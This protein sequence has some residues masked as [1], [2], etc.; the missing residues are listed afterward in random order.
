MSASA[1]EIVDLTKDYAV[2]FWRRSPRRVLHGLTLRVLPGEVFGLLGPNGAGKSTTLKI[3]MRLIFPTAGS[4]RIL[5]RPLHDVGMHAR[6]GFLPEN[7][8]YYDHLTAFELLNFAGGLF[9]LGET[10]RHHR[11]DTLLRRV[12]LTE[13]RNVPLRKFSKGM[14]QRIGIAQALM[15]D[16]ELVILDEPMS[17]L[18]PLGRREVRDLILGLREEGKTVLFSTHI[19]P[20]AESLCDHVAILDRGHLQGCGELR[21]ILRMQT[22]STEIV[23]DHPPAGILEVVN[24]HSRSQIRTG[25]RVR[26]EI[27]EEASVPEVLGL[28]LQGNTKI[29][30]VNPV[31][32]S[33]E[34]YFLS[35]VSDAEAKVIPHEHFHTTLGGKK[36]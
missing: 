27:S 1:I 21:E 19:L 10:E 23:V 30:S 15:N 25:D 7:P 2:G 11:A 35:Q 17:G 29:I 8:Y 31:K 32:M 5:D 28:L 6:I 16:P 33:L 22:A 24:M 20:D 36:P 12:G 18:D 14:V 9:G 3:L 34:D 26:I 4:A 13:S